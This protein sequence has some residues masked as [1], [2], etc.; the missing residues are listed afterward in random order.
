[1][2]LVVSITTCPA[3]IW[4][5]YIQLRDSSP[6]VLFS[7]SLKNMNKNC[8]LVESAS[9]KT[10]LKVRMSIMMIPISM[11]QTMTMKNPPKFATD[12]DKGL[13]IIVNF[14]LF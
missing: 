14:T 13:E 12:E 1:M 5:N 8:S 4:A 7:G 3:I 11:T 6:I 9:N 2:K 10:A